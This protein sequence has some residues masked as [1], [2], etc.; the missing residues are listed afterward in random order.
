MLTNTETLDLLADNLALFEVEM[1]TGIINWASKTLERMF[2]YKITGDLE[3]RPIEVLIPDDV[4]DKHAKEHRPS[5]A[6]NPEPRL[7]GRKL[8]L[9][10]KRKDDS[11]FPVE[12]MLLPRAANKQRVIVGVVLDLSDRT[13]PLA[14]SLSKH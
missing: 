11:V 6:A 12:V 2:G 3:G 10:G 9:T 14:S 8:Y 1:T 4:R 13:T 7:M 5:F